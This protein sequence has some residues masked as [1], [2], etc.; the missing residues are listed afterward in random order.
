MRH[1]EYIT[2]PRHR[3]TIAFVALGLLMLVLSVAWSANQE[4]QVQTDAVKNIRARGGR[5]YYPY[6][7]IDT[8]VEA[9]IPH[10]ARLLFGPDVVYPV[11]QVNLDERQVAPDVLRQIA[12]LKNIRR[13]SLRGTDVSD[14]DL[15]ELRY[16][17]S[18]EELNLQDTAVSDAG[19]AI[20]TKCDSF[21]YLWLRQTE[22]S[23]KSL[24]YL[25]SLKALK[26]L[27]VRQT[28]ITRS[29]VEELVLMLPKTQ[30]YHDALTEPQSE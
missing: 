26:R 2:W 20:L 21:Q 13:L 12:K 14:S 17:H 25:G 5:V 9:T 7:C 4:A 24:T 30:I 16:A 27:D 10:C 11:L 19:I 15:L 8:E 18:L 6:Q 1:L 3:A 29:G 28:K 23:D 22:V